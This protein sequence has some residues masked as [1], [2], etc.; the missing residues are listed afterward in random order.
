MG[1]YP[2]VIKTLWLYVCKGFCAFT[3]L[4]SPLHVLS[5]IP[6]NA[7]DYLFSFV[8]IALSQYLLWYG[9]RPVKLMK[10]IFQKNNSQP[11]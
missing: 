4:I 10:D 9:K 1:S 7:I 8:V 2:F 5:N 11:R 3:L 6:D